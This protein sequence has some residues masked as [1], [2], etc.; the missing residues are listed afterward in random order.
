VQKQLI[1]ILRKLKRRIQ[2]GQIQSYRLPM[3]A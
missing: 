3:V 1:S 2:E